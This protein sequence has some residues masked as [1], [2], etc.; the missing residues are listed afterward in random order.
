MR[1]AALLLKPHASAHGSITI[2][3]SEKSCT[4]RV[5]HAARPRVSQSACE[6][7]RPATADGGDLRIETCR[8][9]VERQ[10]PS[11]K[12]A[13]SVV[14]EVPAACPLQRKVAHG[15]HLLTIEQL[16][17][18]LSGV[19]EVVNLYAAPEPA[20]RGR[21]RA[22]YVLSERSSLQEG[23]VRGSRGGGHAGPGGGW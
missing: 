12:Q 3:V 18:E 17:A 22:Q 16:L 13:A 2:R 14:S 9:A 21:Y 20:T 15:G 23:V 1:V 10:N 5:R 6:M 7:G 11:G 19:T 4:F 8:G